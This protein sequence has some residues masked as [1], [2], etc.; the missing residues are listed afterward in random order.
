MGKDLLAAKRVTW[1]LFQVFPQG[2]GGGNTPLGAFREAKVF[3]LI[4]GT[5]DGS[6][7]IAKAYFDTRKP[8]KGG[9]FETLFQWLQSSLG[10][11]CWVLQRA[12][13]VGLFNVGSWEV[14][15]SA[16][17]LDD[18]GLT[19]PSDKVRKQAASANLLVRGLSCGDDLWYLRGPAPP[20]PPSCQ[21]PSGPRDF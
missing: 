19:F 20:P 12:F 15:L 21:P 5:E 10:W 16:Q 8:L 11:R 2:S 1:L 6:G 4:P 17:Q 14:G 7:S 9:R 18:K 13:E 3:A